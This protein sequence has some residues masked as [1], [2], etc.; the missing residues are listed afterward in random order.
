MAK[1]RGMFPRWN[2][3]QGF[4]S[5]HDNIIGENRKNYIY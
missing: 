4:Y 3:S 5:L 2:T 1:T